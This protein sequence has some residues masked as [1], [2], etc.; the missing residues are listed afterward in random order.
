MLRSVLAVI[1]GYVAIFVLIF[2]AFTCAYQVLGADGAFKPGSFQSSNRWLA[3]AFVVNFIVAIIG[4][5]ICAIVAKGGKAPLA[6]AILVFVLGFLFAI[7]SLI[8]ANDTTNMV[9][10]GDVPMFEAIQKTKQPAWVP[11]LFPF[12]GAAGVLV[13]GKLKRRS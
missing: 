6:L 1:A 5:L 12:V 4:G 3:I 10:T 7:P 13:G 2:L 8:A 11:L 9:R